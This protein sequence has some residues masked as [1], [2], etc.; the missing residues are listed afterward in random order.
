M[1]HNA[2]RFDVGV[3]LSL[4]ARLSLLIDLIENVRFVFAHGG[5]LT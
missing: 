2:A 4:G 3:G 1:R 5:K